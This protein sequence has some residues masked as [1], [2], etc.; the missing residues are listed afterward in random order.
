MA[1][2]KAEVLAVLQ[3]LRKYNYKVQWIDMIIM[4]DGGKEAQFIVYRCIRFIT[5]LH[6][7]YMF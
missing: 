5:T 7:E 3:F 6:I 1:Q 4:M 2:N